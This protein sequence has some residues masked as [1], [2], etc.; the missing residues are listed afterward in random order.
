MIRRVPI[1][2]G[3]ERQ[4]LP[5]TLPTRCQ[6]IDERARFVAEITDAETAGKG[7][8]VK[9]DAAGSGNSQKMIPRLDFGLALLLTTA[10]TDAGNIAKRFV[11]AVATNAQGS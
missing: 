10:A 8:W 1:A 3:S 6:E 7:S 11:S 5:Q 2:G 9:Q 4:D